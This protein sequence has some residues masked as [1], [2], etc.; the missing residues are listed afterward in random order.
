MTISKVSSREFNQH[1]SRAKKAAR[2]G[3]VIITERGRPAHV[4]LTYE[5]YQDLAGTKK[6][7]VELLGQPPGV[8]DAELCIPARRELPRP[9]DLD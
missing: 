3:P 6:S 9:A 7:V 4:L 5:D 1:T 8:E 2:G